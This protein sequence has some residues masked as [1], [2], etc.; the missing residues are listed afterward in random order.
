MCL[1]RAI[2]FPK[3]PA[4]DSWQIGEL[5]DMLGWAQAPNREPTS[6]MPGRSQRE[7]DTHIDNSDL[8]EKPTASGLGILQNRERD[9]RGRKGGRDEQQK[10]HRDR[11]RHWQYHS[12]PWWSV[13]LSGARGI[14]GL[15]L[16]LKPLWN[17]PQMT[18]QFCQT[19]CYHQETDC[20]LHWGCSHIW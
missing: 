13:S 3:M 17:L 14:P 15:F 16:S 10:W 11:N 9:W 6:S 8:W 18:H 1:S 2:N 12:A 20:C 7:E 19:C 5:Q 4:L